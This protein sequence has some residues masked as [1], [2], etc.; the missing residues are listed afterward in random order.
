MG[1][2]GS[3]KVGGKKWRKVSRERSDFVMEDGWLSKEKE[4]KRER[5]GAS[6]EM[7]EMV[8]LKKVCLGSDS[9]GWRMTRSELSRPAQPH[10]YIKL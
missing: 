9:F 7:E 10:E 5:E 1:L 3:K 2:H 8:E 6:E 4:K